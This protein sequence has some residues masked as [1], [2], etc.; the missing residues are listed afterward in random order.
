MFRDVCKTDRDKRKQL[1]DEAK[2]KNEE[3]KRLNVFD[4][5]WIIR[6][7]RVVKTKVKRAIRV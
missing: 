5:K 3:L 4:E 6:G 7:E 2:N 1:V